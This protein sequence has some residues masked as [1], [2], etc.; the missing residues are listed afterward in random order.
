MTI[1]TTSR[2]VHDGERNLIMQLTG[3]ADGLDQEEGVVKVDVSEIGCRT[4]KII[5]VVSSVANGKVKL[6]WDSMPTPTDFL[7][8]EGSG[9][10]FCYGDRGLTNDAPDLQTGDVLLSTEGFEPG[11]SYSILLKMVKKL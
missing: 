1:A 2:V 9:D 6:T 11:S 3:I 8:L 4:V 5:E 10:K 7:V